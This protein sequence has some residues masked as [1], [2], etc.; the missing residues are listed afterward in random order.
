MVS[1]MFRSVVSRSIVVAIFVLVLTFGSELV[2]RPGFHPYV[3]GLLFV[4]VRL[5]VA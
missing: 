3:F 2:F 1:L 4:E 5:D